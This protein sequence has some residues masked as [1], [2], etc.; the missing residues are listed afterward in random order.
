MKRSVTIPTKLDFLHCTALFL[1]NSVMMLQLWLIEWFSSFKLL[2]V[3][4][5]VNYK[6]SRNFNCNSRNEEI[7]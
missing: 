4:C 5:G 2:H 3:E 6:K 1:N 7:Q